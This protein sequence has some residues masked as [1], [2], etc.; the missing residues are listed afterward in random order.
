MAL[1]FRWDSYTE[2]GKILCALVAAGRYIDPRAIVTQDH[3]T[4]KGHLTLDDPGGK[5]E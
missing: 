4:G 2:R 3:K 1:T 5:G